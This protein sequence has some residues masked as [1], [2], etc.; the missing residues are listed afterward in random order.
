MVL[1]LWNKRS[2]ITFDLGTAGIRAYQFRRQGGRIGLCDTLQLDRTVTMSETANE[3]TAETVTT[4]IDAQ[5]VSRLVGQGGFVGSD[6]GLVL[7][8]PDVRFFPLQLPPKALLQPPERVQQALRWEVGRA[9][10]ERPEHLEVRHWTLPRSNTNQPNVMA[11]ALPTS[12]VNN[13]AAQLERERLTLR[14]VDVAPCALVRL[15]CATRSPDPEDI[16]GV[17]DLGQRHS[18]LTVCVGT[19]PTYIRSFAITAEQWTQKLADAFEITPGAAEQLK[20]EHGIEPTERRVAADRPP[21]KLV[22]ASD[23]PAV[24]SSVLR[25]SLQSLAHE[26]GRCFGYVLH[27]FPQCTAQHLYLS[28][29]SALLRGL[30]EYLRQ[31]LELPVRILDGTTPEGKQ[32][33]SLP[34]DTRCCPQSAIAMGGALLSLEAS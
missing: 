34:G 2:A 32:V 5:Q 30:P 33:R 17:L 3:K 19:A 21:R 23:L 25:A 10:R 18:T 28:G 20:R 13:W 1:G 11:V 12:V 8:S 7:S 22:Q 4:T 29:G 27:G 9:S 16:W 26:I 15:A 24:V 14:R 31:E 6:V